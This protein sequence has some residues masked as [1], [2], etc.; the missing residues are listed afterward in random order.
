MSLRED[1]REEAEEHDCQRSCEFCPA[2]VLDLDHQ[3][4]HSLDLVA[5]QGCSSLMPRHSP[6]V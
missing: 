6:G 3:H 2:S 1:A 5:F 4:T